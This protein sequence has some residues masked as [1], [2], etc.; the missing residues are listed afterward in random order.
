MDSKRGGE[1]TPGVVDKSAADVLLPGG[2]VEHFSG[3]VGSMTPAGG[4]SLLVPPGLSKLPP[5]TLDLK[6]IRTGAGRHQQG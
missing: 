3:E 1:T 6:W 2:V 4:V 5:C